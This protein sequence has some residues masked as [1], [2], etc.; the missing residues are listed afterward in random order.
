MR[1][2]GAPGCRRKWVGL[3]LST[4]VVSPNGRTER[5]GMKRSQKQL[6]R[7]LL[8]HLT[9]IRLHL[10]AVCIFCAPNISVEKPAMDTSKN[11]LRVLLIGAGGR[12]HALVWK[13]S[14]APF[15][16]ARLRLFPEMEP[17]H[18]E[19]GFQTLPS[20]VR[21]VRTTIRPSSSSARQLTIGLVVV[22][23]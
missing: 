14:Q 5:P 13:L 3:E 23:A 4:L 21:L 9:N 20:M 22:G 7:Q 11:S 19:M 17:R 15:G 1:C 2:R 6:A 12:E 18:M 16:R 10:R 8:F